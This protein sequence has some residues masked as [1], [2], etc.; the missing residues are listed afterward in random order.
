MCAGNLTFSAL[1]QIATVERE[2]RVKYRIAS[3]FATDQ[4]SPKGLFSDFIG[5]AMFS[6]SS[7]NIPL[8][9]VSSYC[10]QVFLVEDKNELRELK[11]FPS[12]LI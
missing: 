5:E 1:C 10:T 4:K 12:S 2:F 7:K 9:M 3:P 11:N 6:Y 8:T